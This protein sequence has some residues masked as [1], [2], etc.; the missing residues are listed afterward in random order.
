MSLKRDA[1]PI[2]GFW[3]SS[4]RNLTARSMA[5]LGARP[6]P[7]VVKRLRR[8]RSVGMMRSIVGGPSVNFS[9]KL[10]AAPEQN[11]FNGLGKKN[12]C[13]VFKPCNESPN[14]H[15]SAIC[16]RSTGSPASCALLGTGDHGEI[17]GAKRAGGQAIPVPQVHEGIVGPAEK[18]RHRRFHHGAGDDDLVLLDA[19]LCLYQLLVRAGNGEAGQ[20]TALGQQSLAHVLEAQDGLVLLDLHAA[21]LGPR[22]SDLLSVG[23][24]LCGQGQ[25]GANRVLFL[26]VDVLRA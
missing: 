12:H 10:P 9:P 19:C 16:N 1:T 3:K 20:R 26:G 4:S 22:I 24:G 18:D 11:Y 2:M 8:G 23:D 6:M 15:H 5:R 13:M 21:V 25:A 7:S 14:L 17:I